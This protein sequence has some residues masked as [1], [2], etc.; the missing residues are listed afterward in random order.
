[1]ELKE[2]LKKLGYRRAFVRS[3]I[4]VGI[5]FQIRALRERHEWTQKQLA[6]KAEML[7]PRIS[8]METPGGNMPNLETLA[9][10]ADAYDVGLIVKFAP[11]SEMV[12]WAEAFDPD[13]F[14]V[15][16][17]DNDFPESVGAS[18]KGLPQD[19]I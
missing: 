18:P 11:F 14:G 15:P 17:F 10:F 6:E 9:R 12:E 1:M 4:I 16:E 13:T 2:K 19:E 3:Q 8:A 7:Q 5:P